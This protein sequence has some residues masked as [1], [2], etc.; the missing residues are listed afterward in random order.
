MVF[1]QNR[2]D[3]YINKLVISFAFPERWEDI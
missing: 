2:Q 3:S 1:G